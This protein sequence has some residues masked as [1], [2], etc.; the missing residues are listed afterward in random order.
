MFQTKEPDKNPPKQ[1]NGEERGNLPEKEFSVMIARMI[2]D[3]GKG[4]ET[5][6]KK[7]QEIFNKESGDLKNKQAKM[8]N[9]IPEMK[10]KLEGNDRRITEAEEQISEVEDRVVEITAQGKNKE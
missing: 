6:I 9:T 2:Q 5:P 4:M 3:L 7:L 1:L 10:N 8:S